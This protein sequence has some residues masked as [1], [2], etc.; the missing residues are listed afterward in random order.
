MIRRFDGTYDT[1]DI[2]A[3]VKVSGGIQKWGYLEPLQRLFRGSD[4]I[5]ERN[6]SRA[7]ILRPSGWGRSRIKLA[8]RR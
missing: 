3:T 1:A 5:C 7:G 6:S 2:E 4:P 8:G